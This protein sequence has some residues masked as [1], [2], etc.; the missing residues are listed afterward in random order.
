MYISVKIAAFFRHPLAIF[1]THCN[2]F[3]AKL[4]FRVYNS[5]IILL[6]SVSKI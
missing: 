1:H 4:H 6:K 2:F 5:D 3:L